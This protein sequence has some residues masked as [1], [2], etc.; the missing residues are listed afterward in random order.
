MVIIENH[1]LAEALYAAARNAVGITFLAQR[2]VKTFATDANAV[3][4]TLDDGTILSTSLLAAADGG[5]SRLRDLAGIRTIGH[6]Y[7]QSGII[8]LVEPEL[9]HEGH[10]IQHFLP[11]GPFALLPMTDNRICIT[12]SE[13]SSEARRIL[14][15]AP[16]AFRAEVELRFGGR[17]GALKSISAPRAWPLTLAIAASLVAPRFALVGDAAHRV[18]PLAGQGI[19]LGF[20]DV[21]AL[22]E[23][24][25]DAARLGLDIGAPTVLDRYERWRRFD[26]LASATGFDAIN[27][28]FALDSTVLRTARGA[29]LSVLDRLP[30]LKSWLADEAAGTTGDLPR[31]L[32]AV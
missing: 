20:R 26:N 30:A 22:T 5:T 31:L 13:T 9:P 14:A 32:R 17:L 28:S 16:D 21:A 23:T 10:A 3:H 27:R 29:V 11:S 12:W 25:I 18:H 2:N 4:V 15:L 19:N 7:E 8:T 1:H 24:I 6:A